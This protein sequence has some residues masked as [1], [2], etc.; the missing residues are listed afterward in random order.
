MTASGGTRRGLL[1]SSLA[2][3]SIDGVAAFSAFA[4]APGAGREA[5]TVVKVAPPGLTDLGAVPSSNILL[6]NPDDHAI[7]D[8]GPA[9]SGT[10]SLC[11]QLTRI[12]HGPASCT[13]QTNLLPLVRKPFA[14]SPNL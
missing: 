14:D 2:A 3:P 1:L 4:G 6:S 5:W 10:H 9:P 12:T 13:R 8:F 7:N 11:C